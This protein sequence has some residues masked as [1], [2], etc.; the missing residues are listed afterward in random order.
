MIEVVLAMGII[1][2]GMT[3]IMGLFPVGINASR[4][5]VGYNTSVEMGS[6]L[7]AYM[8]AYASRS[9]DNFDNLFQGA[10]SYLG[11]SSALNYGL[12]VGDTLD[13]SMTTINGISRN[14][15]NELKLDSSGDVIL[16][17]SSSNFVKRSTGVYQ[18]K[19][20]AS[21]SYIP[22]TIYGKRIYLLVKGPVDT[23]GDP[24]TW[25][26]DFAAMA[27][28]WKSPVVSPVPGSNSDSVTD[29]SYSKLAGLNIELSWPLALNYEEREKQY[30]YIELKKP[31][32]NLQD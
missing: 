24:T 1:A 7:I 19:E 32:F 6:N 18:K 5:A 15:T 23:S 9:P 13:N 25:K 17:A 3:S 4:D 22:T 20:G 12:T 26:Y 8:R 14:F 16:N 30:F 28:V 29:S 31:K 11:D 27:I 21:P 2:V 10:S